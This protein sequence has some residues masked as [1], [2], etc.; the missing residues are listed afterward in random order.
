[1]KFMKI[2]IGLLLLILL[3]RF[4]VVRMKRFVILSMIKILVYNN[5]SIIKMNNMRVAAKDQSS[6]SI[7]LDLLMVRGILQEPI[8]K[9]D[10]ILAQR[11]LI[12]KILHMVIKAFPKGGRKIL[13]YHN[14]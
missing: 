14:L 8:V 13:N 3:M 9:V 2:L 6:Q 10:E 4:P 5:L 7:H 12:M 1:M 11:K